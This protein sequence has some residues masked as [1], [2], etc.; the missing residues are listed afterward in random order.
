M[1]EVH[2]TGWTSGRRQLCCIKGV[3][4][5]WTSEDLG[6][7]SP[8]GAILSAGSAPP[9]RHGSRRLICRNCQLHQT[10]RLLPRPSGFFINICVHPTS[11]VAAPSKPP[12]FGSAALTT[13]TSLAARCNYPILITERTRTRRRSGLTDIGPETFVHQCGRQLLRRR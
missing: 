11:S 7:V 3:G 9:P 5:R 2:C 1:R 10:P 8:F 4:I 13:D 12:S 6:G